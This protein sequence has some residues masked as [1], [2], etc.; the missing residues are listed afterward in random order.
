MGSSQVSEH[1]CPELDWN[2]QKRKAEKT[3]QTEQAQN[4]R[5]TGYALQSSCEQE[6][7][8]DLPKIKNFIRT[9]EAT[10]EDPLP[11]GMTGPESHQCRAKENEGAA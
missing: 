11:W 7:K 3:G 2:V 6:C 10:A 1:V 9:D 4:P 8:D 5:H